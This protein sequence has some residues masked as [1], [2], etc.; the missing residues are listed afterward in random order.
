MVFSS[1]L[2]CAYGLPS[3]FYLHHYPQS[4]LSSF[5][6]IK[7]CAPSDLRFWYRPCRESAAVDEF[8]YSIN[9]YVY[10]EGKAFVISV[11]KAILTPT[12][13]STII[14]F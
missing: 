14:F 2:F 4:P 7:D 11:E 1:R 3:S 13:R 10:V 12:L 9:K 8:Y 6:T 5:T